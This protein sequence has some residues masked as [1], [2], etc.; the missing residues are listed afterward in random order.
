M[1]LDEASRRIERLEEDLADLKIAIERQR[2]QIR[3]LYGG[4]AKIAEKVPI[5]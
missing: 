5:A 3:L 4:M 2:E 1:N